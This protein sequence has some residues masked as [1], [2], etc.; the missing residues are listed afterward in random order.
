M[1]AKKLMIGNLVE[2]DGNILEVIRISKD[3]IHY[4]TVIKSNGLQTNCGRK[5]PIAITLELLDKLGLRIENKPNEDIEY[6]YKNSRFNLVYKT[7]FNIY[8]FCHDDIFLKKIKYI[9]EVQNLFY[10]LD[11]IDLKLKND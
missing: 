5:I 11:N 10:L 6:Y 1:E 9:H 2:C 4:E 8:Y 7:F 3:A